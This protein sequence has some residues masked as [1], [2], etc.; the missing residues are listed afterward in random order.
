MGDGFKFKC[1]ECGKEY[2]VSWGIGFNF[3]RDYIKCL[4]AV[5]KG[6][7]GSEWKELYLNNQYVQ[8]WI[9]DSDAKWNFNLEEKEGKALKKT[10]LSLMEE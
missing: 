8:K 9:Q 4:L 10:V 2:W 1:T 5:K 7:Y 6:K 3:P